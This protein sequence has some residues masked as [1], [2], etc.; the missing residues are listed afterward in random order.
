[1][2]SGI[3]SDH[4]RHHQ[5]FD[6][7]PYSDSGF[8]RAGAYHTVSDPQQS[9]SAHIFMQQQHLVENKGL[10]RHDRDSVMRDDNGDA[11][12]GLVPPLKTDD[13][14][15][16]PPSDNVYKLTAPVEVSL[17][18]DTPALPKPVELC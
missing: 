12:K 6:G 1:M 17:L 3:A 2:A 16:I 15:Q 11:S 7:V 10:R 13:V 14:P 8:S 5:P 18:K 4:Q 9:D